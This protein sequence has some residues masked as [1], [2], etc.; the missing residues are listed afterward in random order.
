M[1]DAFDKLADSYEQ[2]I[3]LLEEEVS[4]LHSQRFRMAEILSL[5]ADHL[6]VCNYEGEE[7]DLIA[8][9]A[10]ILKEVRE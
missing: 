10:A 4:H 2:D 3:A 1:I 5:A 6:E 7:D 8:K 9:I